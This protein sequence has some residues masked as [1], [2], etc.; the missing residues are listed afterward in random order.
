[1]AAS[2]EGPAD[3][4]LAQA[5][6]HARLAVH[7]LQNAG[8]NPLEI[9]SIGLWSCPRSVGRARALQG[10]LTQRSLVKR[11]WPLRPCG[12]DDEYHRQLHHGYRITGGMS[13]RS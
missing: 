1:M 9:G 13:S 6:G 4:V 10:D 2:P 5:G 3:S 7:M 8:A 12:E 11:P